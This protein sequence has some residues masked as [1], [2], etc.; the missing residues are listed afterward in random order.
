MSNLRARLTFA[1]VVSVIALFLA[2]GGSAYAFHL[3]KNSVG[4]KQLKKNAVVTA[5]IKKEAVTAN[6]V[7]KGT[8]TGTQ[9]DAST[10]G[11]VPTAQTANIA[12]SVAPSETFHEVGAPGQ[13]GFLNGWS[14][15]GVSAGGIPET[16][17]FY[18]DQEGVVHLRGE[19][20]S[21]TEGTFIFKLPPG[22]RPS[23]GRVIQEPVTCEGTGCPNTVGSIGIV[24]SKSKIPAFEGGVQAPGGAEEVFLDGVTFRAES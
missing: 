13:P 4:S 5:K 19:A 3:G 15:L 9:I 12:N 7:K 16:V 2:L 8:L 14:N 6:K 11:T 17:A 1:N 20:I 18:K 22:D 10:L 23:S 21:G 24:G